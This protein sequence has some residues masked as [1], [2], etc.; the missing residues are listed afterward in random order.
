MSVFARACVCVC[1]CS[2]DWFGVVMWCGVFVCGWVFARVRVGLLYV[3][4][5]S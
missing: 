4:V 5:V 2:V 3:C 1:V